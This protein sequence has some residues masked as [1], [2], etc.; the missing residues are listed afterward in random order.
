MVYGRFAWQVWM[1]IFMVF[2]VIQIN[3]KSIDLH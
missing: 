3:K 2:Q 1:K